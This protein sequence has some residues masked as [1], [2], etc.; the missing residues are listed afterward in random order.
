LKCGRFI[1]KI[2]GEVVLYYSNPY[3]D[4]SGT[5][6]GL[7]SS[8]NGARN[9]AQHFRNVGCSVA[10]NYP[11]EPGDFSVAISP[12]F[13]CPRR[14]SVIKSHVTGSSIG[15]GSSW[16]LYTYKW[17]SSTGLKEIK[18]IYVHFNKPINIFY[19]Q[20]SSV[21]LTKNRRRLK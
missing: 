9:A 11:V 18:I 6:T 15:T 4:Y 1:S 8:P 10:Y 16:Y 5:P 2:L 13:A 19:K 20:S 12:E 17:I 21:C 7:V 3:I 14:P